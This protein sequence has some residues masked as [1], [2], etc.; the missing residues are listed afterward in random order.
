MHRDRRRA[1]G[2]RWASSAH[3]RLHRAGHRH[4]SHRSGSASEICCS[5]E[6]PV[7]ELRSRPLVIGAKRSSHHR[8]WRPRRPNWS[9]KVCRQSAEPC[10]PAGGRQ[11]AR[12]ADRRRHR[13]ADPVPVSRSYEEP[14]TYAKGWR[15]SAR[16][17]TQNLM[18]SA[19]TDADSAVPRLD[20]DAIS[21]LEGRG[22]RRSAPG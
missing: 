19:M 3:D 14:R 18:I 21:K 2:I 8:I 1:L 22:R 20:E 17:P 7:K 11:H 6:N 4:A 10:V 13:C 12:P 5:A 15:P 9:A 16:T